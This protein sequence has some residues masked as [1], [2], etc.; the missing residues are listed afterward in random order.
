MRY[1]FAYGSNMNHDQM[2]KRC[3]DAKYFG[4][5]FLPDYKLAFTRNSTKWESPVADILVSTGDIVWGVIY[6]VTEEDLKK[7]DKCEG[8]PTIY[9]RRSETV[10]KYNTLTFELIGRSDDIEENLFIDD[11][12]N[13]NKYAALEVEVYEVV[14]KELNL[15]PKINYLTKLQDAAFE[16]CFPKDYQQKLYRFGSNDYNKRLQIAIDALLNYQELIEIG[17]I[18]TEVK[19]QDEWGGANVVITGDKLRKEQLNRDHPNDLVILTPHWRE[20]SWLVD[21]IYWDE[22]IAWQVDYTNKHYVLNQLGNGA[23]EYQNENP[24]DTE[25]KGICL[26]VLF[27]AY[28]V[29]TSDFYKMY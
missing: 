16:Y 23:L 17:N 4:I 27:K 15:I 3:P 1:Y 9:K 12:I 6:I 28:K 22:K 2:V 29:F 19:K 7:L 5:G 11:S 13:L 18:P 10:M 24:K 20:L 25:P 14:N 8:H 21:T 26:A